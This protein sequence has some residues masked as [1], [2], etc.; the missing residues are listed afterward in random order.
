MNDSNGTPEIK[1]PR[2][3]PK[4]KTPIIPKTLATFSLLFMF[5]I[6]DPPLKVNIKATLLQNSSQ[7]YV[8]KYHKNTYQNTTKIHFY[9]DLLPI[10]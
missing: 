7:K 8:S 1:I 10:K 6:L 3:I 4:Q 5:Y 9:I 2:R